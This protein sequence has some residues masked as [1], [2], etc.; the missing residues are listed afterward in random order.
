MDTDTGLNAALDN[1]KFDLA[2]IDIY[3]LAYCLYFLPLKLKIPFISVPAALELDLMRLPLLPSFVPNVILDKSDQMNFSERLQNIRMYL[4]ISFASF[5][6]FECVNDYSLIRK[7]SDDPKL[8]D[9]HAVGRKS[10]MF[11]VPRGH[12]LESPTPLMPHVVE[13]EGLTATQAQPL[14]TEIIQLVQGF[15]Q[16]VIIVSFGSIYKNIPIALAK[17]FVA[18]FRQRQELVL[19]RLTG[20]ID[21]EALDLPDNVK[22]MKWL[23]QNDLLGHPNTRLFITHSGNNG[24]YEALYHGIPMVAAPLSVEQAHNAK[25]IEAKH[26]G[27]ILDLT[28]FS[29]KEML[30]KIS[31]VVDDPSYRAHIQKASKIMRSRQLDGRMLGKYWVEHVLEY[32]ADHLRSH[33][34]DMPWYAFYMVDIIGLIISMIVSFILVCISICYFIIKT[35]ARAPNEKLKGKVKKN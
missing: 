15:P 22:V 21:V 17:K 5:S 2:L 9:W 1:I 6:P 12:L 30:Q 4:F 29:T 10:S 20:N 24:Q 26:F 25:R 19:W 16:G 28:N 27:V 14:P 11:F 13:L 3:P 33:A 8:T 18:A 35:C 34:S 32:G 23:P 7:Y 31:L